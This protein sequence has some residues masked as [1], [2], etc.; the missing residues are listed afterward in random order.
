[1]KIKRR[2]LY[3]VLN[4]DLGIKDRQ[5]NPMGGLHNV[6]VIAISKD[7]KKVKVKTVTSLEHDKGDGTRVFHA[8][9][10]DGVRNGEIIPIPA[11]SIG[12]DRLEGINA[13][14]VWVSVSKLRKPTLNLK[15]PKSHSELIEKHYRKP[16]KMYLFP[17]KLPKAKK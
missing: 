3:S 4:K 14:G 8:G 11:S 13:R 1:M 16:K 5:G 15:Y 17:T 2:G 9:A 7:K 10:L 6:F 12:T